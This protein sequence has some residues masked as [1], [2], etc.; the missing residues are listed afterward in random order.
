M[1]DLRG[2]IVVIVAG[3]TDNMHRFLESNPGL[4]SRFDKTFAFEDYNPEELYAIALLMLKAENL[5][6]D[7][8]SADHLKKYLQLIYDKRDKYFG[9]ARSVRKIIEE[10]VKNRD[11]RLAGVPK[12]QRTPE[13]LTSITINDVEEFRLAEQDS[14]TRKRI[15]FSLPGKN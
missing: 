15:G 13:M 4:K 9:N 3:Y 7:V 11:L 5:Y 10:A 1:E 8:D 6:P 2:H 14:D 12:G